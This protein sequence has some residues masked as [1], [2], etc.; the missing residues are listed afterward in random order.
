M[1]KKEKKERRVSPIGDAKWAH[2]QTPKAAYQGIGDAKYQIDVVF[3][4]GG[5]WDELCRE[6][7][8]EIKS[9]GYKNSPLKKE[10]NK[11]DD[12][13]GRYFITFKTGEQYPPKIFDKHGQIIPQEVLV[14]N[15]SKVRVAFTMA[16]YDGFGGGVTM[17]LG[18]VQVIEL[19]EY[20]GGS[21]SDYG[22]E[23]E[24]GIADP[25]TKSNNDDSE[26]I[27]F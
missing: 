12:P 7:A 20:Q 1:A 9:N 21:A 25:F 3:D 27:P 5:E 10:K 23:V 22:F 19:V 13:T 16:S 2:V 8:T 17:Y 11:D 18:A 26:D 24:E 15:G 14:G 4:A 6:I